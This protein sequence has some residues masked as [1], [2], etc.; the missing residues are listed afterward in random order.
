MWEMQFTKGMDGE[1]EGEHSLWDTKED[2]MQYIKLEYSQGYIMECIKEDG[3][4]IIDYG[5]HQH[6][7]RLTKCNE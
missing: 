5:S 6:F 4:T 7:F 1:P 2:A 3:T